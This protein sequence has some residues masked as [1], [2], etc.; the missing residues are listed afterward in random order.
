[1][2]Q[3]GL[4]RKYNLK[5]C[6]ALIYC[7]IVTILHILSYWNMSL[8]SWEEGTPASTNYRQ[9][10]LL[11]PQSIKSKI[12][13]LNILTSFWKQ[14]IKF[15]SCQVLFASYNCVQ[16]GSWL[17]CFVGWGTRNTHDQALWN[18]SCWNIH[19]VRESYIYLIYDMYI[20]LII[21]P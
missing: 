18:V 12:L 4:V 19:A 8:L 9:L 21:N 5:H 15:F 16:L 3:K 6:F 14:S 13:M 1:M 11:T 20:Y 2:E 17:V 7:L 10:R